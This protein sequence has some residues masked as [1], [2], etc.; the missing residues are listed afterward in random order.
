[1]I[2]RMDV[3][4]VAEGTNRRARVRLSYS[5]GSG[6]ESVF[7]KAHSRVLHR[8][9]L[10]AL[11]ALSAEARLADSDVVLPLEHPV[12]YAGGFDPHRL[13]TVVVMEDVVTVG[14]RPNDASAPLAVAEV[15]NGL[16]ELARLH[17][18]FWDRPLPSALGFVHPWRLGRLWAPVSKANLRR[19]L[20][21]LAATGH[22]EVM[23]PGVDARTLER[24]F[25]RSAA[26]AATGPQTLLHGDPHPGNTYV[27][28][29]ARTGFYDWQLVRTGNWSHDVGYF[30]AGSL[31]VEDRR[32]HEQDL[33]SGYIDALRRGGVDAPGFERAWAQYRATPAF[34]LATWLHTLAVGSFQP[35]LVSVATIRRF[36]TAYRDLETGRCF[37]RLQT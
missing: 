9:A 34:G 20:W 25:R 2:D 3:G 15:R 16:G 28:P 26:W 37:D 10:L 6:P 11:R 29:A 8:L 12:L 30:L 5:A 36:A 24:Q 27:L 1:V 32:A 17:A 7:V 23:P 31:E 19:G 35:D 21:R 33:L 4:A 13:A 22:A 14:G 18:A